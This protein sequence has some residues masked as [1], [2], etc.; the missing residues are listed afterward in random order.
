M[1]LNVFSSSETGQPVDEISNVEWMCSVE[2][3]MNKIE[4]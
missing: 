3:F 1:A 2:K 4:D